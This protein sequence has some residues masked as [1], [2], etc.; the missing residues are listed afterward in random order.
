MDFRGR[1][2]VEGVRGET[3]T[4][5]TSLCAFS[6]VILSSGSRT[7]SKPPAATHAF[8]AGWKVTWRI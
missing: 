7:M 3:T 4:T 2:E 1:G 5:T 8:L 6:A